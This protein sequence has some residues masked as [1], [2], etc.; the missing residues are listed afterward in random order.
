MSV[1]YVNVSRVGEGAYI[2]KVPWADAS[3]DGGRGGGLF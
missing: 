1:G 3:L 2:A